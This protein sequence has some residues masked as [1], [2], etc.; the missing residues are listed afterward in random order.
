MPLK[1]K[2]P[3]SELEIFLKR[4]FFRLSDYDYD[5]MRGDYLESIAALPQTPT[6]THQTA[7][8]NIRQQ[9]QQVTSE[10]PETKE[11]KNARLRA[12]RLR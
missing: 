10:R 4:A 1:Q 11:E 8:S 3:W 7:A 12:I 9:Q 2:S 6:T 5:L